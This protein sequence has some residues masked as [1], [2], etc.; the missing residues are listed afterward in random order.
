MSQFITMWEMSY[1]ILRSTVLWYSW[2]LLSWAR[3]SFSTANKRS[4]PSL[5]IA[6]SVLTEENYIWTGFSDVTTALF[7]TWHSQ[8]PLLQP[9][10]KQKGPHFHWLPVERNL[11]VR[12]STQMTQDYTF[13]HFLLEKDGGVGVW[14]ENSE[15]WLDII[16][17]KVFQNI[18]WALIVLTVLGPWVPSLVTY[19][20]CCAL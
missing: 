17:L 18:T 20:N 2:N 11:S 16:F 19:A 9:C 10:Q 13:C 4:V 12:H 15:Y 3:T 7:R 8:H 1:Q 5:E 14:K 6:F